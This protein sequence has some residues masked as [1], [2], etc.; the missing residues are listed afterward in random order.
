MSGL[1][2]QADTHRGSRNVRFWQLRAN[3]LYV[4]GPRKQTTL[5]R[6]FRKSRCSLAKFVVEAHAHD[7][8]G[9]LGVPA[10]DSAEIV[11]YGPTFRSQ[12]EVEILSLP[13][14]VARKRA[15]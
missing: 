8:V 2:A 11:R 12:I 10:R 14:P 15:F 6:S 5:R 7:V 9:E 4:I 1:S 3:A 13:S